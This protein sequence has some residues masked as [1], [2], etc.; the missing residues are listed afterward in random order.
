M[1]KLLK[2]ARF[3]MGR[4]VPPELE[5]TTTGNKIHKKKAPGMHGGAMTVRFEM[6]FNIFC[7]EC[8]GH[9][10][11]GVRFNADKKKVGNYY[12]TP[13]FAFR[14]KHIACGNTIEIRTDPKN[15]AYEVTEGGK[16]QATAEAGANGIVAMKGTWRC[17]S[18]FD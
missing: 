12:S 14:M 10:A 5:G 11:Q 15:T 7:G 16:K 17:L 13:I 2:L 8:E 18:L 4:Y 6:P 9:I 1:S 3:N